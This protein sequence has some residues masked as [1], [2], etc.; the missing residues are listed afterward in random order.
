[1]PALLRLAVCGLNADHGQRD[2]RQQQR[3][4]STQTPNEPPQMGTQSA[5]RCGGTFTPGHIARVCTLA[6]GKDPRASIS[7]F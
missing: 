2:R 6:E 7:P 1:M 4:R 5:A 3:C